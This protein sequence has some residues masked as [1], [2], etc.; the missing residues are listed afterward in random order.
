MNLIYNNKSK[1][2]ESF[3]NVYD[4]YDVMNDIMSLGAHRL[5]KNLVSG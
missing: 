4:K 2:V 3:N 1:L 5:W